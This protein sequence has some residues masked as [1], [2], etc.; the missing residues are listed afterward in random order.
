MA[1]DGIRKLWTTAAKCALILFP[2]HSV[3]FRHL[4]HATNENAKLMKRIIIQTKRPSYIRELA[5][6]FIRQ[7]IGKSFVSLHWRY[8][9][10]DWMR[11]CNRM[12]EDEKKDHNACTIVEK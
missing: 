2:Y 4:Q 7:E 12:S 10:Q 3:D 11:R 1:Q 9:K 5:A 8:D 6:D